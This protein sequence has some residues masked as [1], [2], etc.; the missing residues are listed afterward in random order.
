[1]YGHKCHVE[2]GPN[3]SSSASSRKYLALYTAYCK[4]AHASEAAEYL[5][6]LDRQFEEHD[7]VTSLDDL[8]A[9]NGRLWID[10]R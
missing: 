8:E 5:D 9:L 3:S 7:I 4:A 6:K 10:A 2:T 1:M